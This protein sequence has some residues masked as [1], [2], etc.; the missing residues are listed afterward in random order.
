[1]DN[2]MLPFLKV[3]CSSFPRKRQYTNEHCRWYILYC[4]KRNVVSFMLKSICRFCYRLSFGERKLGKH[5]HSKRKK[6]KIPNTFNL[7]ELKHLIVNCL[8]YLD[9]RFLCI[10]LLIFQ[11][12]L[13]RARCICLII[14]HTKMYKTFANILK[15][16]NQGKEEIPDWLP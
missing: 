16:I 15:I 10:T 13:L 11:M 3:P 8:L 6:K 9:F 2:L 7:V 4:N 1:M 14:V 12:K 5:L